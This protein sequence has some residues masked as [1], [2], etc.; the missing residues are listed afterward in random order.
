MLNEQASPESSHFS[1]ISQARIVSDLR[2]KAEA[3]K[4]E[5]L[6]PT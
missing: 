4:S 1:G 2:G 5:P 6:S 3:M